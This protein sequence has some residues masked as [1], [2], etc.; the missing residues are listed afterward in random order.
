MTSTR[1]LLHLLT[2]T[3]LRHLTLPFLRLLSVFTTFSR[4]ILTFP[5]FRLPLKLFTSSLQAFLRPSV[6]RE[7][8]THFS[9]PKHSAHLIGMPLRIGARVSLLCYLSVPCLTSKFRMLVTAPRCLA[10][11]GYNLKLVR[12][13][14]QCRKCLAFVLTVPVA[15]YARLTFCW[16]AYPSLILLFHV[17]STEA[18]FFL[19]LLQTG[20][21]CSPVQALKRVLFRH[22]CHSQGLVMLC[23]H[24][25][26]Q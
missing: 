15:P 20:S 5:S 8:T 14:G 3:S 10:R 16:C 1:S 4:R 24:P 26:D 7:F 25:S 9:C 18:D 22:R 17:F 2:F 6:R 13:H 23:S 19:L 12:Y 21:S 11:F